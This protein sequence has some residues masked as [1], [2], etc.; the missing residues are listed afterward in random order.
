ML[1]SAA[2]ISF[3]VGEKITCMVDLNN[4]GF[5][6]DFSFADETRMYDTEI[7]RYSDNGD[8]YLLTENGAD[9][10]LSIRFSWSF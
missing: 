9:L 8:G 5:V 2:G 7:L 1:S 3:P 10:D 4:I 6:G